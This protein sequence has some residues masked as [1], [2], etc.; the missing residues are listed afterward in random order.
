MFRYHGNRLQCCLSMGLSFPSIIK[1]PLADI[2]LTS[3]LFD[4]CHFSDCSC[5]FSGICIYSHLLGH[6]IL[7]SDLYFHIDSAALYRDLSAVRYGAQWCWMYTRFINSLYVPP[8]LC[9]STRI[10]NIRH[11]HYFSIC[12]CEIVLLF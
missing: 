1:W 5:T 3:I 4:E 7:T 8:L 10:I 2:K 11:S 6:F 12:L 9:F